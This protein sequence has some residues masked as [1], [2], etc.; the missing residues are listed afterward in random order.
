MYTYSWLMDWKTEPVKVG[1]LSQISF[2]SIVR[3]RIVL[4][5]ASSI[6]IKLWGNFWI[7]PPQSHTT[8][9]VIELLSTK[10]L[11]LRK[12]SS[13]SINSYTVQPCEFQ[14]S[15]GIS[16]SPWMN[17]C[18]PRS[19]HLCGLLFFDIISTRLT[20]CL[21]ALFFLD[22]NVQ[23]ETILLTSWLTKRHSQCMQV[24]RLKSPN[25]WSC[26]SGFPLQLH[27][28]IQSNCKATFESAGL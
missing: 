19:W 14:F 7:S 28:H 11:M 9:N 2:S 18:L 5:V 26:D 13:Y 10:V 1:D 4:A 15:E 22:P 25:H 21:K 24:I 27:L 8:E 6:A 23:E 3:F 12:K 17:L 16:R 20:S